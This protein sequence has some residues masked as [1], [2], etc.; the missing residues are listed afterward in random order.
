V[1]VC[2]D[3]LHGQLGDSALCAILDG[4]KGARAAAESLVAAARAAGGG[5]N[6]TA[7]CAEIGG[8]QLGPP[9]S[10]D[11]LPRFVEFDP[12]EEGERALHS[13]SFVVRRLAAR[14]GIGEDPGE[15]VVPATGTHMIVPRRRTGPPGPRIADVAGPARSRLGDGASWIKRLWWVPMVIAAAMIGWWLAAR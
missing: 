1:L 14:V 3:G 12:R 13:T 6:I 11:D 8:E 5:D 15:P 7:V 9:A 4:A 2:S 10:Q